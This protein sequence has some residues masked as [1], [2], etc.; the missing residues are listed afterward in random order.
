MSVLQSDLVRKGLVTYGFIVLWIALSAIVILFNKYI[1]AYTSFKYPGKGHTGNEGAEGRPPEVEKEL[2]FLPTAVALTMSHMTFSS[3]VTQI[4]VRSGKFKA[5][6]MDST[7]YT[8]AILPIGGLFALVLWLGNAAYQYLSVS[9]IQ[10]L[11]ACITIGPTCST[12]SACPP[13]W[14]AFACCRP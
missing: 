8:Q 1:L 5:I 6:D 12:G 9:F 10:M 11:K 14:R 7:T 3:V 13:I 2:L 4:L